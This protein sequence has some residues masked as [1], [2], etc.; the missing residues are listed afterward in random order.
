MK[1]IKGT[2][3]IALLLTLGMLVSACPVTAGAAGEEDRLAEPA[4]TESHHEH[5]L[6]YLDAIEPTA[7]EQGRIAC[8]YCPGCGTY[9]ADDEGLCPMSEEQVLL[10]AW[11]AESAGAGEEK[12]GALPLLGDIVD[13]GSFW[14]LDTDGVLTINNISGIPDFGDELS[15]PWREYH[16]S[17]T[18]LVTTESTAGVPAYALAGCGNL[19][20]VSLSSGITGIGSYAFSGCSSLP[21]I[22]IPS[23]V[24]GIGEHAFDGCDMLTQINFTGTEEQWGSMDIG[25]DAIPSGVTVSFGTPSS[26]THSWG[27]VYYAWSEDHMSCT[28]SRVCTET[29]CGEIESAQAAVTGSVTA[30]ASCTASGERTYTAVFSVDWA[31]TRVFTE[32]IPAAGH[33][34]G[35]AEYEWTADHMSCTASRACGRD[36]CPETETAVAE[37]TAEVIAEPTPA[38]DGSKL[39]TASFSADWAEQQEYEE[40][41][42]ALSV[43]HGVCGENLVWSLDDTGTLTISGTGDMEDYCNEISPWAPWYDYCDSIVS[44]ELAGGVTRIGACA[45]CDCFALENVSVPGSVTSIGDGAFEA[46]ESLV[47]VL[48][49]EGVLEIAESVFCDCTALTGVSLPASLQSIGDYAFYGCTSLTEIA[50]P[51]GVISIGEGVFAECVNLTAINADSSNKA[52]SSVDGVL[53]TKA[54]TRLRCCPMGKTAVNSFPGALKIIENTAFYGC[55]NLT[56]IT[57]PDKVTV[58]GANAFA[59]CVNLES[60]NFPAKLESIEEGAFWE[61]ERLTEAV[62]PEGTAEIRRAAFQSCVSLESV[63][64]PRSLVTLSPGAFSM[65]GLREVHYA[66]SPQD[67]TALS[68]G[69]DA[70]PVTAEIIYALLGSGTCG[71]SLAWTL[72]KEGLLRIEGNGDMLHYSAGGAPWYGLRGDIETV[73]FPDGLT[74]IGNYALYGCNALAA[75]AIPDSV[76]KIGQAAFA[77]C[78]S[79]QTISYLGFEGQWVLIDKSAQCIPSS[80]T[81]LFSLLAGDFDSDGAVTSDD[82]VYLLYAT[83]MPGDYPLNQTADYDRDGFVTS[84]DAVYV[85]YFTLFPDMYSLTNPGTTPPHEYETE[86]L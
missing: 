74:A 35:P 6:V 39:Y 61:C 12:T 54:Q 43:A 46:C 44:V 13:E 64:L 8:R 37:V 75:A 65:S 45:F 40:E 9:F 76:T 11:D 81:I 16:A 69:V 79:L 84:D 85:L 34:W 19:S 10:N 29:G 63:T 20:S 1:K 2:R 27:E 57:I 72:D 58:I 36:G 53:Y 25:T 60:V 51:S 22:T 73:V 66:G 26:H 33:S 31:E 68:P 32:E 56:A 83:L 23:G 3:L 24:T 71:E 67:W 14:T 47:S 5:S 80:V 41:I 4:E 30:P 28:A 38:A 52:F 49:P 17:I 21:S 42:P 18:G 62:L 7:T 86:K 15:Q 70:V 50:I 55:V 78:G 82:A 48:V 59:W 77:G